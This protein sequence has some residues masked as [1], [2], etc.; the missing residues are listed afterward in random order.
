M[1]LAVLDHMQLVV[2]VNVFAALLASIPPKELVLVLHAH[3]E[4]MQM[5]LDSLLA[6][7]VPSLYPLRKKELTP[8]L[9]AMD[10]LKV[11]F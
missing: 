7:H 5:I 6:L 4:L 10:A 2:K 11:M 3:T 8:L 9:T 1:I